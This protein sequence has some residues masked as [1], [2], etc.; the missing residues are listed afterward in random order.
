MKEDYR[1][2]VEEE[3]EICERAPCVCVRKN[4]VQDSDLIRKSDEPIKKGL[5]R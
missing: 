1:T 2:E 4:L 3:C 5:I